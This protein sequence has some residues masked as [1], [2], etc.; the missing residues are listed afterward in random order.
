VLVGEIRQGIERLARRGP[1]QA[2]IFERWLGR[3]VEFEL[4]LLAE[5]SDLLAA[6]R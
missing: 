3:P 6:E 1:A 5:L 4:D 2:E